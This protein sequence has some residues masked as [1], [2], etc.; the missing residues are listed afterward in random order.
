VGEGLAVESQDA[1]VREGLAGHD[2]GIVDEEFHGE[3]VCAVDHEVIIL[4]D[5]EGIRRVEK[6]VKGVYLHLGINGLHLLLGALYLG[7]THVFGEMDDLS[8]QVAQVDHV[9]IDHTYTPHTGGGKIHAHRRAKAA[10]THDEHLGIENLL[11]PLKSHVLQQDVAA[12]TLDLFFGQVDH[13]LPP[14]MK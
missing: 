3:I 14:P 11:L 5:V 4:D 8:L 12:V 13:L 10:G 2:A 9:G 6:L 1:A 7:H